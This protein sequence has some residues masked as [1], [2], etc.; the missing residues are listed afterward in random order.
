MNP[1]PGWPGRQIQA[2]RTDD[3]GDRTEAFPKLWVAGAMDV[4][5]PV[6]TVRMDEA[7]LRS[8]LLDN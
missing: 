5:L 4:L 1:N 6:I 2:G 8:P 7:Q 3:T